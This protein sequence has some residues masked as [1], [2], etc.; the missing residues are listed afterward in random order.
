[1]VYIL[2]V[3]LRFCVTKYSITGEHMQATPVKL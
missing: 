2:K 1:M 3:N